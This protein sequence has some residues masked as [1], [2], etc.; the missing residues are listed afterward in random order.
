M[1]SKTKSFAGALALLALAFGPAGPSLG[2]GAGA[3]SHATE[4]AAPLEVKLNNGQRWQG[5]EPLR[6]GMSTIRADIA[7]A[8]PKIHK[9]KFTQKQYAALAG[10]VHGQI[11]Y[12][13]GNCKLPEEADLVLHGILEHI[14]AGADELKTKGSAAG[15]LTIVKALNVYGQ[16]FDHPGWKPIAH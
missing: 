4:A 14:I 13:V 9:G 12:V 7:S 11:D 10:K 8:L 5:D 3:H 2:A 6:K 1:I 15:A 16:S